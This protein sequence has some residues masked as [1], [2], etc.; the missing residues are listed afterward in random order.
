MGILQDIVCSCLINLPDDNSTVYHDIDKGPLYLDNSMEIEINGRGS[1]IQA[2]SLY[3]HYLLPSMDQNLLQQ[4]TLMNFLKI[5]LVFLLIP[6]I[7]H[8]Q[9]HLM[10]IIKQHKCFHY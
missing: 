2:S 1:T 7:T 4:D 3:Y 6:L 10:F 5:I 9:Y 8:K